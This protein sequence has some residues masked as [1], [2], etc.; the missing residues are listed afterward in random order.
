MDTVTSAL[1]ASAANINQGVGAHLKR[2]YD[3]VLSSYSRAFELLGHI[4]PNRH[5]TL[6][7]EGIHEYIDSR[8][9]FCDSISRQLSQDISRP[10]LIDSLELKQGRCGPK[11]MSLVLMYN[12]GILFRQLGEQHRAVEYF[13]LALKMLASEKAVAALPSF[14]LAAQYNAAEALHDMGSNQEA[15]HTCIQALAI[16][17]SARG[18]VPDLLIARLCSGLGNILFKIDLLDEAH[19][20]RSESLVIYKTWLECQNC[21]KGE[22]EF[23]FC[24]PSA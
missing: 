22:D 14:V 5:G 15:V 1:Q 24:A 17:R 3:Q 2:N 18:S 7:A 10:L 13:K 6:L 19:V 11:Q 4:L 12:A 23:A 8:H 16:T 9:S 20:V 21:G